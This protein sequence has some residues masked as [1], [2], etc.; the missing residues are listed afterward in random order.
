MFISFGMWVFKSREM[1]SYPN[2]QMILSPLNCLCIFVKNQS[3][4]F[5]W[6]YILFSILFPLICVFIPLTA[7]L[8]ITF[9]DSCY[10]I[11]R[12]SA[13]MSPPT[14][15]CSWKSVWGYAVCMAQKASDLRLPGAHGLGEAGDIHQVRTKR[16]T[17]SIP[18]RVLRGRGSQRPSLWT[19]GMHIPPTLAQGQ[20]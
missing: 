15:F 1:L 14:L 17:P 13:T 4:V 20:D 7:F 10:F 6:D 11:V 12:K 5:M 18:Q 3:V 8:T 9:L 19:W 16:F 2:A